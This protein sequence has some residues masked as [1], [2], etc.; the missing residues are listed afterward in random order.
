MDLM[1]SGHPAELELPPPPA[2]V[3]PW[4][5]HGSAT[6]TAFAGP[7]GISYTAN[8]TSDELTGIGAWTED[9]FIG[10]IR[11]GRHWGQSRPILPPMPWQ[12]YGQMTDEDLGA[13]FAY[14]KSVPPIRNQVPEPVLAGAESASSVF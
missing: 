11:T 5:W 12:V 4:I 2:A 7:W 10:A 14:L 6:N 1:L 3:G 9:I 13:I 8:L